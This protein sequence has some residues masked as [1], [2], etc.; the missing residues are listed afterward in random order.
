[1]LSTLIVIIAVNAVIALW[2][3]STQ[4]NLVVLD[5]NISNAMS[6]IGVQ[7]SSRFNGLMALLNLTKGYARHGSQTLTKQSNPEEVWLRQNL[8]RMMYFGRKGL[9]LKH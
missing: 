2:L 3:I 5:E 6:Q 8:R 9:F 1:M 4:R 7:L